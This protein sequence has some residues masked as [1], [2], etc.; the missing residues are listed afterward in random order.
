M[1]VKYIIHGR[2]ITMF[3]ISGALIQVEDAYYGI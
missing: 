1:V 3:Y 2:P